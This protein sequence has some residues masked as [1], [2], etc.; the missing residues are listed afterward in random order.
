LCRV[1]AAA[2]DRREEINILYT[3]GV[4]TFVW[5]TSSDLSFNAIS[6]LFYPISER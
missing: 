2:K 5:G 4:D 3:G 1:P 6:W